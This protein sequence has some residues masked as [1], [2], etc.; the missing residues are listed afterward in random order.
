M[1]RINTLILKQ[2]LVHLRKNF[3]FLCRAGVIAEISLI[4]ALLQGSRWCVCP[5][6]KAAQGWAG[7]ALKCAPGSHS[8]K[9]SK[10][11]RVHNNSRAS[12]KHLNSRASGLPLYPWFCDNQKSSQLVFVR[13]TV[14]TS[15][16]ERNK[17]LKPGTMPTNQCWGR[18]KKHWICLKQSAKWQDR[19]N[20][21]LFKQFHCITSFYNFL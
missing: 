17:A 9:H 3:F 18:N 4:S 20:K 2:F 10:G 1:R 13:N 19:L 5:P 6:S 15:R 7:N 16:Q 8:D 11:H 12:S 14:S 21:K